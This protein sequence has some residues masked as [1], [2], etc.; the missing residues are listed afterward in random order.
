MRGRAFC[1]GM[2]AMLGMGCQGGSESPDVS[3][4]SQAQIV[5]Q[6]FIPP[7]E[8][9]VPPPIQVIDNEPPPPRDSQKDEKL[10]LP[11][12]P[13]RHSDVCPDDKPQRA[14]Y[15]ELIAAK[16]QYKREADA[17]FAAMAIPVP[18]PPSA[19]ILEKQRKFSEVA[20]ARRA[21]LDSLSQEERDQA[22]SDLKLSVMGE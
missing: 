5:E 2:L 17:R 6:A 19:A 13:T 14:D 4:L 20:E 7:A 15:S 22:W 16:E 18:D 9:L 12:V 1:C 8:P 21:E 10:L 11:P 3:V